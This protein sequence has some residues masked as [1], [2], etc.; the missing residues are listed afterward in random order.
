MLSIKKMLEEYYLLWSSS[1]DRKTRGKYIVFP[2]G[3]KRDRK[4]KLYP[5]LYRISFSLH[6]TCE[7]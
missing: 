4:L 3:Q 7:T 2:K 5:A 1:F 6:F